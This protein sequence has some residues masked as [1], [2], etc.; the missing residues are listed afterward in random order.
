MHLSW[1]ST[2]VSFHDDSDSYDKNEDWNFDF[3]TVVLVIQLPDCMHLQVLNSAMRI[4]IPEVLKFTVYDVGQTGVSVGF[5]R[6]TC[7]D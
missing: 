3:T 5:Y 4:I 2:L 6:V 1:K 7:L